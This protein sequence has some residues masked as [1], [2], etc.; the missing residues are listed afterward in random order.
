MRHCQYIPQLKSVIH[1]SDALLKIAHTIRNIMKQYLL[2][3][4]LFFGYGVQAQSPLVLNS[5]Q[6]QYS[7]SP[8]L[9]IF[10]D[11]TS[12]YSLK[13]ILAGK[14][15]FKA[16]TNPQPNFGLTNATYWVKFSLQN[17]SDKPTQWMIENGY[18]ITHYIDL[19]IVDQNQQ[20][21]FQ[22]KG[23]TKYPFKQRLVDYRKNIF[24][25]T[26]PAKT[27]YTYFLRLKTQTSMQILLTAWQPVAFAENSNN[28][29]Y[30][31]GGYVGIILSVILY[32]LFVA[33]SLKSISYA[34]YIV[35][36]T[37]FGLIQLSLQGLA[38]QY[39]WQ[40]AVWWTN[41][42]IPFLMLLSTFAS[43]AFTQGF[44]LTSD[45]KIAWIHKAL[46]VLKYAN[47]SFVVILLLPYQ[48]A[49]KISSLIS[50][51]S[52]LMMLV[53]GGVRLSEGY[54]PA[55]YFCIAWSTFV[56]GA[57]ILILKN[58]GA[59]PTN[60]FTNHTAA[61]GSALEAILL[62]VA[63][64]DKI[65][66]LTQERDE[67]HQENMQIQKQ[68]NEE[69]ETKVQLRTREI[70][71]KN[72][73]LIT[74]NEEIT[75][76]RDLLDEQKTAIEDQ[77][78][79]ITSSINYAQRIQQAMLPEI[80]EIKECFADCFVLYKP[81]DV[82]SGDF[83]WF[84]RI[85]TAQQHP[86][87][88]LAAA[89]CTGHGVPGGFMSMIGNE[90]LTEVVYQRKEYRTDLILKELDLGIQRVLKQKETGNRDGMDLAVV[91]IDPQ[92]Q[93][94]QFSGAK[95]PLVYIQNGEMTVVKGDK[96]PVGGARLK[97][98]HSYTAHTIDISQPTTFYMYSD[99]YQDQFGGDEGRKFMSRRF[100]DLLHS[101]YQKPMAQQQ[102][103]LEQQLEAWQQN[104]HRQ[105]DDILITGMRV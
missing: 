73:E 57:I 29:L 105:V 91:C 94:M 28:E 35:Y 104:R 40:N 59:L 27:Q 90:L 96:L 100:R 84:A 62:S 95:N 47:L 56:L 14:I 53:A 19:F 71:E 10:A 45:S 58:F 68:I 76:Q 48:I 88:I 55:R 32:N 30:F 77:H 34:Y 43:V 83:Y 85:E 6:D 31:W 75:A 2:L 41:H 26:L 61:I 97:A 4:L 42:C 50:V 98:A 7:L 15:S 60:F 36:V 67:A 1:S 80:K 66:V 16:N 92:A 86:L 17:P 39:L 24:P 5:A 20:V 23:G 69:L 33:M 18:P 64:A 37:C 51:S 102:Q 63:L 38:Y 74:Q 44:L 99:G 46:S 54:R 12:S 49:L 52:L 103:I 25:T 78:I 87:L 82:V 13:D 72:A 65:K 70:A 93:T 81:K 89:D 21:I 79:Q 101:I 11:S 22:S 9:G 3:L 8:H